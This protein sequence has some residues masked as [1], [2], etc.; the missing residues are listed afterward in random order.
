[1]IQRTLP[2]ARVVKAFNTTG[3]RAVGQARPRLAHSPLHH[4]R[5]AWRAGSNTF[6]RP[7]CEGGLWPDMFVCGN[8]EAAKAW[9]RDLLTAWQWGTVDL[10]GIEGARYTEPMCLAWCLVG[11]RGG[12]WGHTWKLLKPADAAAPAGG[13]A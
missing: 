10:G 7:A 8:D 9:V 3:A 1:V 5:P 13:A 6:Y 11:F 4:P 12:G 2:T